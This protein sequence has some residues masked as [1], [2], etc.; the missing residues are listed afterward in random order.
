VPTRTEPLAPRTTLSRLGYLVNYGSS[1]M[2]AVEFG[3]GGPTA[4][5]LSAAGNP[6]DRADPTFTTCMQDFAAKR[7][8]TVRLGELAGISRR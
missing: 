5:V 3:A 6:Q 4:R 1:F 7:W 8:R 2:M